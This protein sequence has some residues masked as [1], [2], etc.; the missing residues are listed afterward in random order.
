MAIM[1]TLDYYL[2]YGPGDDVIAGFVGRNPDAVDPAGTDGMRVTPRQCAIA[3]RAVP[4]GPVYYELTI[5]GTGSL[6]IAGASF[7]FSPQHAAVTTADVEWVQWQY[8]PDTRTFLMF[9]R[10]DGTVTDSYQLQYDDPTG[11]NDRLYFCVHAYQSG[12]QAPNS[13]VA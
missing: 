7:S 5:P 9:L 11:E 6:E 12:T 1:R 13:E 8:D 3:E 2:T 10:Y 4:A